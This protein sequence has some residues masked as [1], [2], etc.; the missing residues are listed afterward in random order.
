[1]AETLPSISE[2]VAD[3]PWL[4]A[5]WARM[6]VPPLRDAH[7]P[8]HGNGVGLS[9][10]WVTVS[11][12]TPLVSEATPRLTHVDP[13]A[14]QRLQP[15]RGCRGKPRDPL[16]VGDDRVAAVLAARSAAARGRACEGALPHPPCGC[17]T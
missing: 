6:G 1:M 7:C 12:L 14:A 8:T 5:Q 3:L 11:W 10:G 4:L 9:L 2:G 13:W 16:D 15:R 17:M